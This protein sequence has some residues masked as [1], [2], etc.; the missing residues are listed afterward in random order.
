MPESSKNIWAPWRMEYIDQLG[1]DAD[2]CFLC[3]YGGAPADDEQNRVVWRREAV[4]VV[5]NRFPYTGGHLLV[6]PIEHVAD[7][8]DLSDAVLGEL[9]RGVRDAKRVVQT[10]L[11]A[12]GF[13]IGLNLGRCA[14]AGLPGHL[15]W[16][17]VP[18][19]GGDTNFMTIVGDVRV[20]PEALDKTYQRLCE[21]ARELGAA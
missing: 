15:H 3:R 19:W 13:N 16:H 6:A 4:L 5:M 12:D 11:Q 2:G 18:R 7:L 8:S 10:T 9:A 17:V 1:D 21:A 14:G 20:V